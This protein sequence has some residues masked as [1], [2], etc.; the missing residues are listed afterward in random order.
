MYL[1]HKQWIIGQ[2]NPAN[3]TAKALYTL[4]KSQEVHLLLSIFVS[5]NPYHNPMCWVLLLFPFVQMKK[6]RLRASFVKLDTIDILDKII[7]L[8]WWWCSVHCRMFR[9]TLDLYLDASRRL[10]SQMWQ[11]KCLQTL[12]NVPLWQNCFHLRTTGI[13]KLSNL[14]KITRLG[15]GRAR[16]ADARMYAINEWNSASHSV[17]V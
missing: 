6:V 17:I 3:I 8:L 9:S 2:N 10:Q 12:S 16:H 4:T 1:L 7:F 15:N 11:P 5:F 14:L 13:D